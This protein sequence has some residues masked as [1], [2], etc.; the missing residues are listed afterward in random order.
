MLTTA[1]DAQLKQKE[2]LFLENPKKD[3]FLIFTIHALQHIHKK[4]FLNYR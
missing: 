3:Y 2:Y 1:L 4:F